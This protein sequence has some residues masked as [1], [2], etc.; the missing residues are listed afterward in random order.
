MFEK[1]YTTNKKFKC[2]ICVTSSEKVPKMFQYGSKKDPMQYPKYSQTVPPKCRKTSETNPNKTLK[3]S[4][5][6]QKQTDITKIIIYKNRKKF[7][8]KIQRSFNNSD[9]KRVVVSKGELRKTKKL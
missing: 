3:N 2:F 4:K 9:K 7:Q 5:H 6:V 1:H 8:H